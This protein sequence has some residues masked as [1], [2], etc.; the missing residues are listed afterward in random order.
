MGRQEK[1][2]DAVTCLTK[3]HAPFIANP[4]F[5]LQKW[6]LAEGL[7]DAMFKGLSLVGMKL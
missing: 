7:I 5:V 4:R 1:A 6:N 2:R 3:E